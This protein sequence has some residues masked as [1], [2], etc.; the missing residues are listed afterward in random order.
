MTQSKPIQTTEKSPSDVQFQRKF[1]A[2]IGISILAAVAFSY[3]ISNLL[4]LEPT[5]AGYIKI[6]VYAI[7]VVLSATSFILAIRRQVDQA[8]TIIFYF[9]LIVQVANPA[10]TQGRIF[11]A[12]FT[13]LVMG[14]LMIG[15]LLPRSSWRRNAAFLAGAFILALIF[16]WIDPSW[17]IDAG[18]SG[19]LGPIVAIIFTL[20][21]II[22]VA[23]EAW[24]GSLRNKLLVSFIGVTVVATGALGV[25]V[26][27]TT[28]HILQGN[29]ERELS[30]VAV[31]RAVRI[32]DLFNE[33]TNQLTTLVLDED[34]QEFIEEQNHSY[35]GDA[36]TIQAVLDERDAQW[37]AA[38]AADNN[39]DYLVWAN[40]NNDVAED[41]AKYQEAFPGNIEVFVTDIYGGIAGTT[42]RTSDYFQ[43]DEGWWQAA[44]ANGE[45]ALYIGQPE[46]DESAGAVGVNIA[47]PIRNNETGEFIGILRT[48]FLLSA[49]E[50]VLAE[51]IGETGSTDL[52]VPGENVSHIH[53]GGLEETVPG[54]FEQLQE[55]Y[56]Q[57]MTEMIYEDEL[58]IVTQ[59]PVQTLEGNPYID[60]LGWVVAF[61]QHRDEAFAPINA[62]LQ[63]TI[64]VMVFVVALAA[65]AAFFIAQL[66]TR[67]ITQLTTTAEEVAA[68]DLTS[69]A[70]VT[71]SDEIGTLATTFNS[72]TTQLRE[73][74]EGLEQRVA[75][76]TKAL[77]TS[78]EVSRRLA[79]ILD[80]GQL[81]GEVVNEVRNAFDYYYAQ[82]YLLDE[83]GQN[84][85]LTSGT[86]EAG[87]AMMGR[88]HSLP[89]G[90][91]LV[92]RAAD[93]N[94]S[95]LVP[96]TAQEEG[97]LPNELL[98]ETKAE[99]AIPIAIGQ[100]VLG[101]LDV[102]HSLVN[103]LTEADV[104]LLESLAGQVAISLQNARSYEQSRSK[105]EME[106][107]V[108]VIGQKIQRTTSMEETLQ[109]AIR[110][111]GTAIGASRVRASLAPA[112]RAMATE[113]IA[114]PE[115]VTVVAGEDEAFD[116]EATPAD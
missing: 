13:M 61:H 6:A 46:Y 44:Y 50:T 25:F 110:E 67:P 45:G 97:W 72:M 51:T 107:L 16:E 86:G 38:D 42:N 40:L 27:N 106:S 10:T 21:L 66:L 9:L 64:L 89:K 111:L 114:P 43:A 57:G 63:G 5:T 7:A 80:P 62:Q 71:S 77:A 69:Q 90:R 55:V 28:T 91:G 83:A 94:A 103:G 11:N 33:Q 12:T 112:T 36:A 29:L 15:W 75:D 30:E 79:T 78:A 60:N 52:F 113:P 95:V 76:R 20:I 34:L 68:G 96:D 39:R 102:Q 73:T 3:T 98:P 82:I 109:T 101:V 81:A 24:R 58:S 99:A 32:G 100:E 48:T 22:L 88:G 14:T 31:S 65:A 23:R 108:N 116:A 115:P 35:E 53:E 4:R 70:Q 87:A 92:G 1:W 105:A 41:L 47:M 17:R 49:L 93:A 54:L 18:P 8:L 19:A 85:V 74:L 37:R 84:L 26:V 56:G 104:T 2:V 59:A